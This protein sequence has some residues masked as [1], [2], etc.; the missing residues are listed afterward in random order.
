[1][2]IKIISEEYG[3]VSCNSEDIP[4]WVT[5]FGKVKDVA[6]FYCQNRDWIV[7]DEDNVNYKFYKE[8]VEN[9]LSFHDEIRRDF[10]KYAF[11]IDKSVYSL[12]RCLNYVIRVRRKLYKSMRR[13]AGKT[14]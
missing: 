2:N 7:L 6:F 10:M 1:M 8:I 4:E 11:E 14:V 5:K 12:L 9:Y 3:I 13:K